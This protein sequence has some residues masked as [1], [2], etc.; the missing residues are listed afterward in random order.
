MSPHP[1]HDNF[2]QLPR[3]SVTIECHFSAQSPWPHCVLLPLPKHPALQTHEITC[4][5]PDTPQQACNPQ[6]PLPSFLCPWEVIYSSLNAKPHATSSGSLSWLPLK[7]HFPCTST[8]AL[9]RSFL[10]RVP[11]RLLTPWQQ[12]LC[13]PISEYT[14]AKHSTRH[15]SAQSVHAS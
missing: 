9:S 1:L 11:P 8:R 12:E 14:G 4:R 10:V 3:T 15:H 2:P 13:W 6:L 5:F 7:M